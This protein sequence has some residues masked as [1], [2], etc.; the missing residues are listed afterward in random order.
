MNY[1]FSQGEDVLIEFPVINDNNENVDLSTATKIRLLLAVKGE[2]AYKYATE[3][4]SGYGT[5]SINAT[6]NYILDILVTRAQSKTFPTGY[7]KGTVLLE[8][9]D[10]VLTTKRYEFTYDVGIVETGNLKDEDLS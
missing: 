2:T 4:I 7:L 5:V 10:A 1:K 9:S 6:N 3:V 8:F